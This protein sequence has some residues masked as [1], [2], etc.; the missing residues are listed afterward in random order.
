MFPDKKKNQVRKIL[1]E[2][3]WVPSYML[4]TGCT[5]IKYI[6]PLLAM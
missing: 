2:T 5:Q 6:L 4:M 1:K 3:K